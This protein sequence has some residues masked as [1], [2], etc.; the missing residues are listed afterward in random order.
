MGFMRLIDAEIPV[1]QRATGQQLGSALIMSPI[2]GLASIVAGTLYDHF[3]SGGYWSG[4]IL[5]T[6]GLILISLLLSPRQPTLKLPL[7]DQ[8]K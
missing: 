2:M 7:E 1:A 4:V 3:S 8:I 6:I 5:A